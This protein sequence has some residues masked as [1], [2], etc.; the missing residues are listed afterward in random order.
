MKQK[1]IRLWRGTK[2]TYYRSLDELPI[3]NWDMVH[4][5]NSYTY[6]CKSGEPDEEAEDVFRDLSYT[7]D[8]LE[9]PVLKAKRDVAVKVIDLI[10]DI[11]AN[12]KDPENLDNAS[13]ILSAI[14][15]SGAHSEWLYS[16]DFTETPNQKQMLSLLAMTVKKSEALQKNTEGFSQT[17]NEKIV[18]I[19]RML[20]VNIDPKTCS[21]NL[22]M[23]YEKQAIE[24]ARQRNKN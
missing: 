7:F 18:S 13:M 19:E 1:S 6:L 12:S 17:L 3:W 10:V 4:K 9:L 22:F 2:T 15:V 23:E 16:I 8:K 24:L 11:M 14:A 20:S 5:T 21:V